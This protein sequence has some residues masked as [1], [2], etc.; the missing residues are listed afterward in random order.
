MTHAASVGIPYANPLA[1]WIGGSSFCVH[2][3]TIHS[4]TVHNDHIGRLHALLP[5]L[6]MLLNPFSRTFFGPEI[7][8]VHLPRNYKLTL[9]IWLIKRAH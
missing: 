9:V 2:D 7:G 3:S 8:L 4:F 6:K 1:Y 5:L